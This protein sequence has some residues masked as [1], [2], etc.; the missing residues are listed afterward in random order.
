MTFHRLLGEGGHAGRDLPVNRNVRDP[1]F[2]H[3]RNERPRFSGVPIEET[4]PFQGCDV[5]HD[6]GL[7]RE[8]EVVLNFT[9]AWRDPFF[10]LL[11]LD[12]F[13]DSSLPVRQHGLTMTELVW[14][15]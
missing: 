12:E 4:L 5:L 14:V 11:R 1:N 8:P 15:R 10:P 7:A 3:R 2:L 13:Q 9:R 6:G